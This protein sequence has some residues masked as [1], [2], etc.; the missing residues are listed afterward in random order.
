MTRFENINQNGYLIQTEHQKNEYQIKLLT[1]K[2]K[3]WKSTDR[4]WKRYI[5]KA[6]IIYKYN[7]TTL[8]R[9]TVWSAA[10]HKVIFTP[11]L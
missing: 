6:A 11:H 10:T 5:H 4:P 7:L 8:E 3:G 9:C 2:L 1:C